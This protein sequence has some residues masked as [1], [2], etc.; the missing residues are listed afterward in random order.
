MRVLTT[1]CLAG[2]VYANTGTS[3]A[4]TIEKQAAPRVVA[5]ATRHDSPKIERTGEFYIFVLTNASN[6]LFIGKRRQL[7][8]RAASDFEGGGV[9]A[10]KVVES[11][12][13][14]GPFASAADAQEALQRGLGERREFPIT[15]GLKGR[16]S[17]DGNW[18]GLWSPTVKGA[19]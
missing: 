1:M 5:A 8:Q 4:P 16:W 3:P 12:E 9:D 11:R 6:G 18:Y 19:I 15:V 13:L 7:E 2:M 10:S 17:K 14:D